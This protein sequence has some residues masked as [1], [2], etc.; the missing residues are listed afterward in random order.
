MGH[1]VEQIQQ[2]IKSFK[3]KYYLDLSLRGLILSALILSVYFILA[4]VVEHNLW[5]EPWARF[6]TFFSFFGIAAY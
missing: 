1:E 2:K 4:A 3:R 6:V 5:L